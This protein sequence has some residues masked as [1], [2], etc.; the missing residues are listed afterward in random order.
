MALSASEPGPTMDRALQFATDR[1][2]LLL[3][4]AGN[5]GGAVEYPANDERVV[6]VSAVDGAL[7]LATFSS[8]GSDV[9]LAA[10][11]VAILGPIVGDAFA[12]GS[13]TSQAVGI[14]AGVAT[15]VRDADPTLSAERTRALLHGSARDLGPVGPDASFG[16]GLVDADAAL[17]AAL[18]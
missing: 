14:A 17:A 15:L 5:T 12:F 8:R 1:D 16:H 13:G 10:P 6:A 7:K 18:A 4:S 2:V 9:E 3:A 11:G